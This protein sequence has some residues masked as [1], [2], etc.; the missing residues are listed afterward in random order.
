MS[1]IK[2]G[3][4]ILPVPSSHANKWIEARQKNAV[5]QKVREHVNNEPKYRENQYYWLMDEYQRLLH[6]IVLQNELSTFKGNP[7]ESFF[8]HSL[9]YVFFKG[10][11]EPVL[12]W[13]F[14]RYFGTSHPVIS[15]KIIE[16]LCLSS[17]YMKVRGDIQVLMTSVF[18]VFSGNKYSRPDH[19]YAPPKFHP[20]F[21]QNPEYNFESLWAKHC[22]PSSPKW[23][24]L[25]EF[26]NCNFHLLKYQY[27]TAVMTLLILTEQMKQELHHG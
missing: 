11:P 13:A 24:A 4:P 21:A 12:Q 15:S 16:D 23:K 3:T 9:L 22:S 17:R 25:R 2:T 1:K 7:R 14:L 19:P 5:L 18:Y 10:I 6:S 27:T 26:L 8:D 20:S